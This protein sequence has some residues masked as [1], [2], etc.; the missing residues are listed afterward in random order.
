MR[1]YTQEQQD[2]VHYIPANNAFSD[3]LIYGQDE[4]EKGLQ[5]N[6]SFM[7]ATQEELPEEEKFDPKVFQVFRKWYEDSYRWCMAELHYGNQVTEGYPRL[8][9]EKEQS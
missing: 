1:E 8:V 3:L 5:K 7:D 4:M 2:S 6:L 9:I